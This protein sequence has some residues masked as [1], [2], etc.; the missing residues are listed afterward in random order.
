MTTTEMTCEF[1][2]TTKNAFMNTIRTEE[3]DLNYENLLTLEEDQTFTE[4]CDANALAFIVLNK[5]KLHTRSRK[6]EED[7]AQ[8]EKYYHNIV[9]EQQGMKR[10]GSLQVTYHRSKPEI[11]HRY[12]SK[13]GLSGQCMLREARHVIFNDQY[14]DVDMVNAHCVFT[15]WMCAVFGYGCPALQEYVRNREAI[16]KDITEVNKTWTRD[17]AKRLMLAIMYGS[18]SMKWSDGST[19]VDTDFV[20]KFR[21]ETSNTHKA[22]CLQFKAFYHKVKSH[23]TCSED[24]TVSTKCTKPKDYNHF[25]RCM[26]L[27]NQAIENQLLLIAYN[28]LK[29]ELPDVVNQ[30]IL[31]YDGIMIPKGSYNE[32]ILKI[33]N[34]AYKKI[35]IPVVLKA[36]A[37]DEGFDMH[38]LGYV[39][40]HNYTKDL[41]QGLENIADIIACKKKADPNTFDLKDNFYLSDFYNDFTSINFDSLTSCVQYVVD[42]LPRV[43]ARVCDQ[44]VLKESDDTPFATYS[45]NVKSVLWK[46]INANYVGINGK[47]KTVSLKKVYE[48]NMGLFTTFSKTISQYDVKYRV[49]NA[50]YTCYPFQASIVDAVYEDVEPMLDFIYKVFCY[51]DDKIYDYFMRWLNFLFTN[52]GEKSGVCV[53]LTSKPGTGKTCFVEFLCNYIL[54][55]H[56]GSPNMRGVDAITHDNNVNFINKRLLVANETA[57]TKMDFLKVF[58]TFKQMITDETQQNKRLF[59]DRTEAKSSTNFMITTNHPDSIRIEQGDRRFFVLQCSE[60]YVGNQ[61]FWT[62]FRNTIENQEFADKFYS[63]VYNMYL[64]N[65]IRGS[66]P[67]DTDIKDEIKKLSMP[68]PLQFINEYIEEQGFEHDFNTSKKID[69]QIVD[70]AKSLYLY[71]KEWCNDNG[72]RIISNTTFGRTISS[73]DR[74]TKKRTSKGFVYVIQS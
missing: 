53:V 17:D 34:K 21:Q 19:V 40:R 22:I 4:T 47:P 50:F 15:L 8:V 25:G 5:K 39:A 3:G 57:T 69:G 54:G 9:I 55:S 58:D 41:K 2:P 16:L 1:I 32:T 13:H 23:Y 46:S 26:S 51:E 63:Y 65:K 52:Q 37:M 48:S 11:V 28:K 30:C 60:T 29:K 31:C 45:V 74:V 62:K 68:I 56:N 71:F 67:P 38:K 7:I 27:I 35:K 70:S 33:L 24:D 14:I 66:V 49:K 18:T 43:A 64:N 44:F 72:H 20:T 59:S 6:E 36:K 73:D 12:T 10:L 42:N 61:E